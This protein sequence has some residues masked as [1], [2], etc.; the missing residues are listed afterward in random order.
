MKNTNRKKRKNAP[1]VRGFYDEV[2]KANVWLVWPAKNAQIVKIIRRDLGMKWEP[3][4]ADTWAGKCLLIEPKRRG[5]VQM[6]VLRGWSLSPESISTL[7]H[8]CFH[9]AEYILS[10][11]VEHCDATSE[12]FA[13]LTDSIMRR[14]LRLLMGKKVISQEW[15]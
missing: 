5:S 4:D 15:R 9:A 13:Y 6:I 7:A 14:C 10:G 8:E 2:W 12:C 3:P 1:Q 11:K